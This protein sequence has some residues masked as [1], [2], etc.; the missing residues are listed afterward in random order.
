MPYVARLS[1]PPATW[2]LIT[3]LVSFF[4]GGLWVWLFLGWWTAPFTVAAVVLGHVGFTL[5]QYRQ[6][7]GHVHSIIG[8]CLG[9]LGVLN[10]ALYTMFMAFVAIRSILSG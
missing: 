4:F 6:K 3:G 2:S 8:L 9:Y 5:A 1:N 7:V 10:L